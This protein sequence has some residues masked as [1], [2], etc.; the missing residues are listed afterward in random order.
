MPKLRRMRLCGIGHDSARFDDVTLDFT[1]REGR[2]TNSILWLRNGGG[3][4]SL[5]SLFFAGVRPNKREF[6]GQ[7]ADE[8]IRRLGD[9]V[10]PQDH[11]IVVCEWELDTERGLFNDSPPRYLSGVMYQ[12]KESDG[13]N[14][15]ADVD[16]LFFATLVSDREPELTLEGLPIFSDHASGRTRRTL[17]GLRRRLRQLDQ[18]QPDRNVFVE[19]RNQTNFEKELDS[20]GIDPQVFFYQIRM[21]EREGGV[22]QL[23]SFASDEDFADFLLEMT[24][25]HQHARQ[26][27]EQLSTFRQEIVERNEQLKPELEYCQGLIARLHKLTVVAH[28]RTVLFRQT[29]HAQGSLQALGEWVSNRRAT[30]LF[31]AEQDRRLLRESEQAVQSERQ[32]ADLAQRLAAVHQRA[33]CELR[34]QEAQAEYDASERARLKAKRQKEIGQAAVPLA[35]V[36][37]ARREA[38]RHRNLLNQK[39]HEFAPELKKLTEAATSFANALEHDIAMLRTDQLKLREEA[40]QC[41]HMAEQAQSEASDAGERAAQDEGQAAHLKAQLLKAQQEEELL[42]EQGVFTTSD[43]SAASGILRLTQ[44]LERVAAKLAQ[45]KLA[46]AEAHRLRKEAIESREQARMDCTAIEREQ[47]RAQFVWARAQARRQTLAADGTLLRLLQTE[48]VDVEAA[49]TGAATQASDELRRVTDTILRIGVESAEDERAIHGLTESELL[50]PTQDVQ[51]LLVW[52][53]QRNV[54]CWSGWE[55]LHRNVTLNERRK[56]VRRLPQVAAGVVVAN[57]DYDRVVEL[58]SA[59]DEAL[60]YRSRSPV[61][62]A[63]ADALGEGQEF[64]WVVVGPTSDAHFDKGA[65]AEELT[66]LLADKSR[67]Q[68]EIVRCQE[69][70]DALTALRH[71]LQQF[72][73]DYPRGWFSDQRQKLDIVESRLED[74]QQLILRLS[75]QQ[76]AHETE[77]DHARG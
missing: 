22:T 8:K 29:A 23:F 1:D 63:P 11:G 48:Q 56:V 70:R 16:R 68:Q 71:H 49:A 41:R 37:D 36:W 3:K 53:R 5:L 44:E 35:R 6:L 2:P 64:L 58:F 31:Q 59:A 32:A 30:L 55:Y 43:A 4:T 60:G 26:V 12:R 15:D 39:L 76:Q 47:E 46:E 57:A 27:R 24:F 75:N 62:V 54:T 40:Q 50:P 66:R 19:D 38:D 52:F 67:R 65:G 73:Q 51:S 14:N 69:W 72:Q 34:L 77:I 61:V 45:L 33:A 18:E 42:R 20:R 9:Y 7:R 10:G 74:A 17:S 13:S 28:E 25:D 21:N